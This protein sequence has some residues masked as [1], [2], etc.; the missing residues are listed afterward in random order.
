MSKLPDKI[1][2]PVPYE[3]VRCH[4]HCSG[5]NICQ[6]SLAGVCRAPRRVYRECAKAAFVG[7]YWRRV[8]P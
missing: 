5:C 8:G 1:R 3:R 4:K 2:V 7:W 6:F